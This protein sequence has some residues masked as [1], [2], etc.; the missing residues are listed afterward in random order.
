MSRGFVVFG[1]YGRLDADI[2]QGLHDITQRTGQRRMFQ[3]ETLYGEI[4]AIGQ[5]RVVSGFFNI[6][7]SLNLCGEVI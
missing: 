4:D 3:F 7:L 6:N 1:R 5:T 2:A